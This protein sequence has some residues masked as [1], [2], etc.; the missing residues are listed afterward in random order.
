M[1]YRRERGVQDGSKIFGLNTW[2]DRMTRQL[3]GGRPQVECGS[4]VW[5]CTRYPN[6]GKVG[7]QSDMWVWSLKDG[8]GCDA[9]LEVVD[10]INIISAM[11]LG[12]ITDGWLQ[13]EKTKAR[14]LQKS[15]RRGGTSK[16]DREEQLVRQEEKKTFFLLLL[17]KWKQISV[18]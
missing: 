18:F 10:N 8:L 7:R 3:H 13:A 5:V 1:W 2:K 6:S 17:F 16:E 15:G 11:R 9:N 4:K 14:K 12:K